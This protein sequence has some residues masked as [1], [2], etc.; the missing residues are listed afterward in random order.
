MCYRLNCLAGVR[1]F[2]LLHW[3]WGPP[4]LLSNV[5]WELFP[6]GSGMVELYLHFLTH[7]HG[8]LYSFLTLPV[9]CIPGD[10]FASFS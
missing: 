8:I 7:L 6:W 3:L 5:Y 2:S 4:S 1:D 9:R 10:I